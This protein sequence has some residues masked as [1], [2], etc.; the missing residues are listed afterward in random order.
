MTFAEDKS[1]VRTGA[2]PRVLAGFLNFAINTF[3]LAGR[4]NIAH[5]RRDLHDHDAVFAA[6][7]I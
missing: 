2:A 3:R 4:A 1:Q 7:G 6:F 5:A